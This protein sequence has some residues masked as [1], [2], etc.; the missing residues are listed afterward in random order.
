MEKDLTY[1]IKEMIAEFRRD[2][3]ESLHRIEAQTVK[4]NGRVSSLESSRTQIWTA[5]AVVIFLGGVIISLSIMAID[6]KI[7]KN[8][9]EVLAEQ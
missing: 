4:T 2:T 8:I 6:A 1:T 9:K 7:A 5:I 3:T